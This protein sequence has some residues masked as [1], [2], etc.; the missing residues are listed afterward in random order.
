MGLRFQAWKAC[1]D[2]RE[3]REI[4]MTIDQALKDA[5]DNFKKLDTF[6]P[7]FQDRIG[8]LDTSY[9]LDWIEGAD[10]INLP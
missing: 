10:H 5:E 9:L 3:N 2:K 6:V 4:A 7:G 1:D 8:N